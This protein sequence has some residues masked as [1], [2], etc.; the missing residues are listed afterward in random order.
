[1][2]TRTRAQLLP[3]LPS[4]SAQQRAYTVS[5]KAAHAP[6]KTNA[7]KPVRSAVRK[8]SV[9]VVH[10]VHVYTPWPSPASSLVLRGTVYT[11]LLRGLVLF[12]AI[13]R[14]F[15][16]AGA[17]CFRPAAIRLSPVCRA[18]KRPCM[19]FRHTAPAE[20]RA[21]RM[22]LISARFRVSLGALFLACAARACNKRQGVLLAGGLGMPVSELF[23][24]EA[25]VYSSCRVYMHALASHGANRARIL[26][27]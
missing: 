5:A 10:C 3:S 11:A 23:P 24:P 15:F 20:A 26:C 2:Q 21:V 22:R 12:P 8:S 14:A 9:L 17:K 19:W 4:F 6:R 16:S 27:G 25:S 18:R 1:M 13:A 7:G